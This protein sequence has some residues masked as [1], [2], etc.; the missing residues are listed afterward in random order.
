MSWLNNCTDVHS[1]H[2]NNIPLIH[3]S[4]LQKYDYENTDSFS[5]HQW[6]QDFTGAPQ[7]KMR[8]NFIPLKY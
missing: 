1:Q 4:A 2:L 8:L 5:N 7:L 3:T 6:Y